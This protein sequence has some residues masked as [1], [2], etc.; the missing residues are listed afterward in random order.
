[1]PNIS[2]YLKDETLK[3]VRAKAKMEKMP[4]S[5]V[6]REAIE[7]YLDIAESK[8]ARERVLKK[9]MK[10]KPLKDWERLHEERTAADACRH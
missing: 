9:L 4:L 2:V 6:I 7:Q 1:M 10:V 3:A 8:E 5:S